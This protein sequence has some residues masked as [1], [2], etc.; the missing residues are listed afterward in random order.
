MSFGWDAM[1]TLV[2]GFEPFGGA[3]FNTSEL[4]VRALSAG[5]ADNVVTAVLPTSYSRAASA[6]TDLLLAH[7]PRM[8]VLLGQSRTASSI[9]LEQ[10]AANLDDSV[11][12]DND[13][14]VR[15]RQPIWSDAPESYPS[16]LPLDRMAEAAGSC[17]EAIE[18]SRDAGGYVCNHVFFVT[19][20]TV[21]TALPGSRCGFVHLPIVDD[22][23]DRLPGFVDVVRAWIASGGAREASAS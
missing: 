4:V 15:R 21:A 16:S 5:G 22:A 2:T 10:V 13:G 18:M 7:R 1:V 3:T 11:H 17:G 19:A 8:T 9:R 20:H 14:A 23:S 6:I 12:P